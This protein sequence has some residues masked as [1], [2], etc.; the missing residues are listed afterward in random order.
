MELKNCKECRK[1]FVHPVREICQDC[2]EQEDKDFEKV[3]EFLQDASTSSIEE[4]HEHTEVKTKKIMKFVRQGRLNRAGLKVKVYANCQ[5]CG[6]PVDGD[7][8]YCPACKD[9]M[10]KGLQSDESVQQGNIG[11]SKGR[12]MFTANRRKG[13]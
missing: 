10:I 5:G 13:R 1:V 9:R 8:E 11:G 2:F 12:K 6:E 7:E 4:I 3:R